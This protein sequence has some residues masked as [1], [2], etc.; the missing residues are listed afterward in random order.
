MSILLTLSDVATRLR[1]SDKTAGKLIRSG[2]IVATDVS[3]PGSKRATWRV[4]ESDFQDYLNRQRDVRLER[5]G[6][7]RKRQRESGLLP[8][9]ENF[10]ET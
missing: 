6:N 3:Q 4:A 9:G 7:G 8:A 2:A 5:S 1:L 10:W